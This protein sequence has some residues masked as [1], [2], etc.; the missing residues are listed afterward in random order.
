MKYYRLK[1]ELPTFKKGE[2]FFINNYGQ[3][4]SCEHEGVVAYSAATLKRFPNV[5][6]DWF[7]EVPAPERD[8]NTKREFF[9]SENEKLRRAFIVAAVAVVVVGIVFVATM[10]I[11]LGQLAKA[12]VDS[13]ADMYD[14][15]CVTQ[16]VEKPLEEC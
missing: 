6:E 13:K 5:L 8:T 16:P 14:F 1:K 4:A 3:L 10:I 11:A 7:E 15:D 9:E 12:T 2:L